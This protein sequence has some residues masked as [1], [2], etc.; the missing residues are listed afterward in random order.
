M[1][2]RSGQSGY[3]T[4]KRGVWW[5]R[6]Y[7]D[8]PGQEKRTRKAVL[9]GPVSDLTKSQAKRKLLVHLEQKGVNSEVNFVKAVKS[10]RTFGQQAAWWKDNKL[11]LLKPSTQENQG[12]HLRKY[13]LPY[14]GHMALDTIGE[15][16]AQE[17]IT[18]LARSQYQSP[19]GTV[20]TLAPKSI[21]NIIGVLK[22]ILGKKVW[23]DWNLTSPEIPWLEQRFFTEAE[24]LNILTTA[25]G[26]WKPLFA[27]LAETGL[28]FG[29]ASGLHVEDLDLTGC[30]VRVRRSVWNGI[31]VTTKTRKGYR[32]VDITP[33][34]AKMLAQHLAGRAIGRV[35][36]TCHGTPLGGSNARRMLYSILEKLKL[37]KGGLHSFRHGR[38]SVLQANGVPG[39]LIK[40]WI[41]HTN[42][43]TTAR[44]THFQESYRQQVTQ[45]V[46][47]LAK[48]PVET[49]PQLP[50]GPQTPVMD[51]TLGIGPS[52]QAVAA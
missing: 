39:D 1:A 48:R 9:L 37:P 52:A 35:F 50:F 30:T 45:K 17:F 42:L 4:K 36:Q 21:Q 14:F 38:V 32:M 3:V 19:N 20:R 51:P 46:G 2:W 15:Q 31:E 8:V 41:G 7:A 26:Q 24:M 28:R 40:N 16:E 11:V 25:T 13:L 18:H 5:G 34:L 12:N 47:L 33:E 23:Q 10:V 22:V 29:E 49:D 6:W 43:R 27:V 44:Y